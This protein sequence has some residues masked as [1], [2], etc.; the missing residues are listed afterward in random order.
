MHPIISGLQKYNI[1]HKKKEY[2][3]ENAV[4]RIKKINFADAVKR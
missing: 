2:W 4:V 1:F 3:I